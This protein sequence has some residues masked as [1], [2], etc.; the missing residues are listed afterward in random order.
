ML[1]F[2]YLQCMLYRTVKVCL[3][4]VCI[5]LFVKC[6]VSAAV[7]DE[8]WNLL[9]LSYMV[10]ATDVLAMLVFELSTLC[11]KK[12]DPEMKCYNSTKT[13]KICLKFYRC[14]L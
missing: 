7:R 3:L 14:E 8:H 5:L 9:Q 13:C 2:F 11:P 4:H 1:Q 6:E 12:V 10:V